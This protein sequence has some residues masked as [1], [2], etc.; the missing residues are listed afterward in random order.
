MSTVLTFTCT[1][2]I[3]L[4]FERLHSLDVDLKDDSDAS[5][6]EATS[7]IQNNSKGELE[8]LLLEADAAGKGDVL[9]QTWKQDVEDRI[10]FNKDQRCNG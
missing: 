4:Q 10:N 7:Y 6:I 5:L 2:H 9:R 3:H 1:C 8:A